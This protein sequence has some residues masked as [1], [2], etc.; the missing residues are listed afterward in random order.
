MTTSTAYGFIA[1][2]TRDRVYLWHRVLRG[3]NKTQPSFSA[4]GFQRID[5]IMD[6]IAFGIASFVLSGAAVWVLHLSGLSAWA[7]VLGSTLAGAV[8]GTGARYSCWVD[9]DG[10]HFKK[11]ELWFGHHRVDH[12]LDCALE[13]YQSLEADAPEGVCVSTSTT[14]APYLTEYCF[15]PTNA[16]EI[17]HFVQTANAAIHAERARLPPMTPVPHPLTRDLEQQTFFDG[18]KRLKSGVLPRTVSWNG[19]DLPGGTTLELNDDKYIDPRRADRLRAALLAN[20]VVLPIC[21]RWTAEAGAR[22]WFTDDYPSSAHQF[23]TEPLAFRGV[24]V[25]P[26]SSIS[27]TRDGELSSF[28]A[29]GET[30]IGDHTIR[31]GSHVMR[32]DKRW[33]V[34]PHVGVGFLCSD[35][36]ETAW[37]LAPTPD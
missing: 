5:A 18:S 32:L 36:F 14:G 25:D 22:I 11:S 7:T 19:I 10:V 33:L 4:Q 15:G 12:L 24:L 27:W 23:A 17:A 37:R 16:S 20:V 28:T 8:L 2:Y 13:P 21:E 30:R 6:S 29:Y 3:A 35:D 26:S 31:P 1:R 9:A 34:T